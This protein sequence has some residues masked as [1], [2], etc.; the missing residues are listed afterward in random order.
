M[1]WIVR[2]RLRGIIGDADGC[3]LRLGMASEGYGPVPNALLLDSL[4]RAPVAAFT[5]ILAF[6]G[7]TTPANPF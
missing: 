6:A 1:N 5:A 3:R 2:F 4:N 7:A